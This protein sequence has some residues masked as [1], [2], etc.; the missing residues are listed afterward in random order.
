M[1]YIFSL[2]FIMSLASEKIELLRMIIDTDDKNLLCEVKALFTNRR[3]ASNKDTEP[4][5]FY[6]GFKNSIHELK[7]SLEGK[8]ELKEAKTWLSEL[9]D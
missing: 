1:D 9:Q 5:K 8:A 7:L 6:K 4:D 2:A 3:K